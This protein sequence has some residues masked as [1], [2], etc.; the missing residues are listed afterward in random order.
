MCLWELSDEDTVMDETETPSALMEPV[1]KWWR[2]TTDKSIQSSVM[3]GMTGE[4]GPVLK[5]FSPSSNK[6]GIINIHVL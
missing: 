4:E 6:G 5:V 2:K 1:V 3:M